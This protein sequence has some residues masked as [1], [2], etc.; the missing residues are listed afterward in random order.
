MPA[1]EPS[2]WAEV[3]EAI[4]SN[5]PSAHPTDTF[6]VQVR[7]FTNAPERFLTT[8]TNSSPI[9]PS[10]PRDR[11]VR[12]CEPLP[13]DPRSSDVPSSLESLSRDRDHHRPIA[14]LKRSEAQFDDLL[15]HGRVDLDTESFV[16]RYA[17][18]ANFKQLTMFPSPIG[19]RKPSPINPSIDVFDPAVYLAKVH[20]DSTLDQLA[21]GNAV[22][23]QVKR[24]LDA[25][26]DTFRSDKFVKAALVEAAF[27]STKASLI[28]ESPFANGIAPLSSEQ[29]F[30][31]AETIL[32]TRYEDVMKREAK[33]VRLK[34]TLTVFNRYRWVFTLGARLRSAASEDVSIVEETIREYQ[35]ALEWLKAQEGADLDVVARAI[36]S[37]FHVLFDALLTRLS[38]GASSRQE[39]TRLV[40]VLVSVRRED[41]LTKALTKR[42]ATALEGLQKAVRSVDIAAIVTVRG[43]GRLESDV[44][45]LNARASSA[46]IDGISH[47]WRLGRVLITQE[48]WARSVEAQ[49]IQLCASYA[50]VLREHLLSD[51]SFV[52][53]DAVRQVFSVRETALSELQVTESCLTPLEDVL[54]EVVDLF[55]KALASAVRADA[56][57][58]AVQAVRTDT[59]GTHAAQTLCTIA[60][61]ALA[62]T[63]ATVPP[64]Q[65]INQR[66]S[67]R[68]AGCE[69]V[70]SQSSSHSEG[71][72]SV[73]VSGS[74]GASGSCSD[75][76]RG[77]T[78]SARLLSAACLEA[79]TI[80]AQEVEERMNTI[81]SDMAGGVLK[82]AVCCADLCKN[83][84]RC[85]ADAA[86]EC[87]AASGRSA[88]RQ[89]RV[90][91]DAVNAVHERAL[92][93]YVGLVGQPLR[94]A[95]RALISFP[96]E[97][98]GDAVRRAAPIRINGVSKSASELTLQ[99]AL[100]AIA[101][102][103]KSANKSLVEKIVLQVV[104]VV[105]DTLLDAL[106]THKLAYHRAAQLWV[107][108][109]FLQDAVTNGA[110]DNSR[111]VQTA[112]TGFFR[113]KERAVQAVL[114]DGFGF[115]VADTQ[116]LKDT[117]VATAIQESMMVCECFKETWSFVR[118]EDD[119]N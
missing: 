62:Q 5:K 59:V 52:S 98:V 36:E 51:V 61:D 29:S 20:H 24:H 70:E 7:A 54:M 30:E 19:H 14:Q 32:K 69:E 55:Y 118:R 91:F 110:D 89:S 50:Q 78:S 81:D 92:Q 100:V 82:V 107:D 26:A 75:G 64:T 104:H 72:G 96:E 68:P 31:Q 15:G 39:T 42:M 109:S 22:L 43:A 28:A 106:S 34:R 25:Q 8:I 85:I 67:D 3:Q 105:G 79:P 114:A 84:V 102:R 33:L 40:S 101:T 112:I 11:S 103:R 74:G 37:G 38:S 95:A 108:V 115:S 97:E 12:V 47:V 77:V 116:T 76:S 27:E 23:Q 10:S 66:R 1:F 49:L 13:T 45:D 73:V 2:T 71:V 63:S 46:F 35:R 99:L 111:A 9:G 119:Q 83:V 21:A 17:A 41:L 88:R 65:T 93:R 94:E 117:V 18:P 113:V 16:R 4:I 53:A 58:A 60:M 90:T 80:F 57:Q 6:V 48:R 87:G 44:A 56:E 86:L